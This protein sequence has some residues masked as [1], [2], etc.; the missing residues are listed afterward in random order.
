M[1]IYIFKFKR[2]KRKFAFLI[3]QKCNLMWD[4]KVRAMDENIDVYHKWI[5]YLST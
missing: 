1:Y 5:Q 2:Q 4:C 3:C